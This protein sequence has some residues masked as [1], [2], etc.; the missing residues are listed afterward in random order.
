MRGIDV[1]KEDHFGFDIGLS[2]GEFVFEGVP[3]AE[4]AMFDH[5]FEVA[6]NASA[7]P[8]DLSVFHDFAA[9][10]LQFS[11]FLS[12]DDEEAIGD[13][14]TQAESELSAVA[15]SFFGKLA[16]QGFVW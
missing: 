14:A 6:C 9:D 12:L 16:A 11:E 5:A 15:G 8:E 7:G 1:A 2:G 13:E 3:V 10:A 4:G